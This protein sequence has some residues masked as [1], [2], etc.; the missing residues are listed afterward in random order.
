MAVQFIKNSTQG[1]IFLVCS[2]MHRPVQHRCSCASAL[3]QHLHVL[4]LGFIPIPALNSR[5]IPSPFSIR[6]ACMPNVWL[7]PWENKG[8][9]MW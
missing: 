6:T 7:L 2:L 1:G 4:K 3:T 9:E 5:P 8:K